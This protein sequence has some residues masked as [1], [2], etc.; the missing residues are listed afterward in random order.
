MQIG[1]DDPQYGARNNPECEKRIAALL[2]AWR[3]ASQPVL[4]T[5]HISSRLGSP[6]AASSAFVAIKP[7]VLPREGELVFDKTTNSAFKVPAFAQALAALKPNEVVFAGMATDACVTACARE[8]KDLGYAV[9]L[10]ADGCATF[11]RINGAEVP[12]PAET[13]H[14]VAL[15]ALAASGIKVCTTIEIIGRFHGDAST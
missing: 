12:Y 11:D 5:R 4:Y 9:A 2:R 10:A 13:V 6:L 8:A 1:L 15:S 7:T 3:S 14:G